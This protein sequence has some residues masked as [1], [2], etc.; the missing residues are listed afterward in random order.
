M[1]LSHTYVPVSI[2][3]PLLVQARRLPESYQ[4]CYWSTYENRIFDSQKTL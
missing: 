2:G 3:N 1:L 4:L